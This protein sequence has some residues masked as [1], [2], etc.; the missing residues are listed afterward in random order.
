MDKLFIDFETYS[1]CSLKKHGGYAYTHHDSTNVLYMAYALNDQKV[2]LWYPGEEL[3]TYVKEHI[4]SKGL[5]YAHNAAFDYRIWNCVLHRDFNWP[6]LQLSQMVDTA[7][8]AANY[9]LPLS[10]ANAGSVMNLDM[11]KDLAGRALIKLLCTPDKNNRQP[12]PID[13]KYRSKFQELCAYCI[14]DV[15]AMR[16]LVYKLP[17]QEL[18]PQEARVWRLTYRFNNIGLPVAYTE[19]KAIKNYLD[20]YIEQALKQVAVLSD[21]EFQTVGQVAKI[22]AWCKKHG[23]PISNL[24]AATVQQAIDDPLCPEKVLQILKLRQE[25]G[26]TSTAKFTKILDLA[27]PGKF[28]S[29]WVYDN[30]VYHGANTGRWTGRGF[31]MHNLP[32][33]HVDNPEEIIQQFLSGQKIKDPVTLGKALIRPMIKAPDGYMLIVSDYSSIENRVLHWLAGDTKTLEDFQTGL[34]QYI[35]M[36]SARYHVPYDDVTKDMRFMGKVIILGCGYQMGADTFQK[37]ALAQFAFTISSHEALEA[38]NAYRAKYELV[39]ELWKGLKTAGARAVLTGERQTF[40]RIT[41]GTGTVNGIRWLAMQLPDGKCLYYKN[42]Q[43]ESRFI[44]RYESMGKVPTITHEGWNS[45]ARKWMRMALTPGRI[46][47]NACQATAREIMAYGMLN[48]QDNLPDISLIGTVHDEALGLIKEDLINEQTQTRFD[49]ELCRVS[50]AES[51]PLQAK[52]YISKR[53]RK[54]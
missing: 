47:E 13:I 18:I 20:K 4:A 44:P 16:E 25:L 9:M 54:E 22:L 45:Y 30:L 24:Q 11:P 50:W 28:K 14:R 7:S 35:T 19:V 23:Y 48:V 53:Y 49:Q 3:P 46:T 40:K 21:N 41:F 32:R 51:C 39:V 42:P 43:M 5:V 33:A 17:R 38:V 1:A 10:L 6:L 2:Q 31:Q 8:I 12:N 52:G 29:Y 15:E 26:R 27:L 36:A 34:D 37:T